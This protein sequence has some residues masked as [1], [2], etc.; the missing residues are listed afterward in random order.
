[1]QGMNTLKIYDPDPDKSFSKAKLARLNE[2]LRG[3]GENASATANHFENFPTSDSV[4][5]DDFTALPKF[6]LLDTLA[7]LQNCGKNTTKSTDAVSEFASSKDYSL[8]FTT[9]KY[10]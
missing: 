5:A 4:F 6:V 10:V 7:H 1:M 3:N 2:E 8:L 9:S